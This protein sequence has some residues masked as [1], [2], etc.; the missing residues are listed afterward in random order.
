MAETK[1]MLGQEVK[2]INLGLELFAETLEGCGVPVVHVD[3]QPPAGGDERLAELLGRLGPSGSKSQ[4][5]M[6]ESE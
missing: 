5:R 4:E 3:W 1:R 2:V 6:Q